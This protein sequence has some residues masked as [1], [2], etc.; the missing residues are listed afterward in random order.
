[1]T[2]IVNSSTSGGATSSGSGV[3]Y[4]A[5]TDAEFTALV[6]ANSLSVGTQYYVTDVPARWVAKTTN[7]YDGIGF[8]SGGVYIFGSTA[9]DT[10]TEIDLA[11][12]TFATRPVS[13]FDSGVMYYRRMTDLGNCTMWWL[14]GTSTYWAPLGG[15]QKVYSLLADSY[16]TTA[17]GTERVNT[18]CQFTFPA[19]LFASDGLGFK[20]RFSSYK[21]AAAESPTIT[22]RF[23][24]AGTIADTAMSGTWTMA[25]TTR[26]MA[27]ELSAKRA[28][29]TTL[30]AQGAGSI[31]ATGHR[32][33]NQTSGA[34][35][36]ALST[37]DFTVANYVSMTVQRTTPFAEYMLTD[38]FDVWI[39]GR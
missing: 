6:G 27:Q 19:N 4:T 34:R 20:L 33:G 32:F 28:S 16:N 5:L 14:G 12:G 26:Q 13:G 2:V 31:T 29:S 11:A 17:D 22:I 18:N 15:E 38:V 7:T 37:Q 24:S 3:G 39:T 36:S 10:Q 30:Q 8:L 35:V 23:G 9:F 21:S 1:M 25:T